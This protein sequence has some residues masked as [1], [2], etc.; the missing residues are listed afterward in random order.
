MGLWG[1]ST[2][3]YQKVMLTYDPDKEV[4]LFH[5]CGV[6]TKIK[7]AYSVYQVCLLLQNAVEKYRRGKDED[8]TGLHIAGQTQQTDD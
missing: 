1:G 4:F 7:G 6:I 2:M 8:I 3:I 5:D